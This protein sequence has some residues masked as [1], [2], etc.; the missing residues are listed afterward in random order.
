MNN[1]L[2]ELR[3]D[4][5][6]RILELAGEPLQNWEIAILKEAVTSGVHNP[7]KPFFL[8]LGWRLWNVLALCMRAIW[9][10]AGKKSGP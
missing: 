10:C 3:K 2:E 8:W 7:R 9:W 4:P 1:L 6:F 5:Q